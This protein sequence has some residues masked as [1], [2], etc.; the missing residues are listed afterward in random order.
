MLKKLLCLIILLLAGNQSMSDN[1]GPFGIV[2]RSHGIEEFPKF[3]PD[4]ETGTAWM[5]SIFAL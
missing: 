2:C 4:D 3:N 5:D 1:D